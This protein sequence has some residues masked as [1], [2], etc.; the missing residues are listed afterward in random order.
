MRDDAVAAELA[1]VMG[2]RVTLHYEEKV[3]LPTTCFGETRHYVTGVTIAGDISLSPGVVVQT[4]PAAARPRQHPARAL[5][6]ALAALGAA[7]ARAQEKFSFLTNWYAQAEH[8]GFYQALAT[9]L[10]KKE[11]LDV[12]PEDGRPAGQRHAA[13]GRR[14]DRLLHG[15]RRADHRRCVSRASMR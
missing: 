6:L 4:A 14:A 10:Y 5:A 8:G 1:K 12:T 15:L 3:G 9:G 7:D 2:K 13:A 11:G